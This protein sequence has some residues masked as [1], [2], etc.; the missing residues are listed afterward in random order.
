MAGR[1]AAARGA[2]PEDDLD[3]AGGDDQ[4]EPTLREQLE[5]ARDEV[6]ERHQA[7]DDAARAADDGAARADGKGGQ[8]RD[9]SGRFG[10]RDDGTPAG[11]APGKGGR[12]AA[13]AAPGSAPGPGAAPAAA[14]A[15]AAGAAPASAGG[16]GPAP[17]LALAPQGWSTAAKAQW[18]ALPEPIRAEVHKR[19]SEIHQA[20]TRDG[21]ERQLARQ[22]AQVST[23]YQDVL[24]ASG[25]HPLRYFDDVLRIMRVL[26]RGPMEQRVAMLRGVAER[27]GIDFRALAGGQPGQPAGGPGTPGAPPGAPPAPTFALPPELQSMARE[28]REFRAAQAAESERQQQA[29]REAQAAMAQQVMTE[30]NAFKAKPEARFFDQ[31]RD[32]MTVLLTGGAAQTLEEA[33]DQ[34][35]HARPD[36]RAVLESEAAAA[37]QAEADKQRR[38]QAA[39]ARGGSVRGGTG[40]SAPKAPQDRTLREELEANFREAASRV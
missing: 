24:Q 28:W 18:A 17:N 25:V 21:E 5:S 20:L 38:I 37:R 7:D 12:A 32:H 11:G 39:R 2:P 13:P 14:A 31:V 10:R 16:A 9:G 22:F 23:T 30:I 8:P 6:V 33:Y 19:E 26:T 1:A 27:N 15:P 36:I 3:G 40:G 34:A 4:P 29:A 35:I